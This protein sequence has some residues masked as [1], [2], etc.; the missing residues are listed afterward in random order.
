[1]KDAI[2]NIKNA[3]DALEYVDTAGRGIVRQLHSIH[4][5]LK[6]VYE[7]T[8]DNVSKLIIEQCMLKVESQLDF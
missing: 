6:E 7:R 1:M 5:L 3:D 8:D 2:D 4:G